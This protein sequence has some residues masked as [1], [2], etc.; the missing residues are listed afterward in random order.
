MSEEMI[1]DEVLYEVLLHDKSYQLSKKKQ[2]ELPL[3]VVVTGS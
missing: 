2:L 3:V 1:D